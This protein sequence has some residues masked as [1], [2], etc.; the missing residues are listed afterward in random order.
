MKTFR[1]FQCPLAAWIIIVVATNPIV[2]SKVLAQG[3]YDD[4]WM[5][6]YQMR[7]KLVRDK[8][9]PRYHFLPPQKK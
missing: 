1:L 5:E 6:A 9:R 4:Y 7:E 3:P 2:G 8:F